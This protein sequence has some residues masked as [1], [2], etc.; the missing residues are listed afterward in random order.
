MKFLNIASLPLSISLV[1]IIMMGLNI[2]SKASQVINNNPY[3]KSLN[4][5]LT[6]KKSKY[7]IEENKKRKNIVII[8]E[9]TPTE[10]DRDKPIVLMTRKEF[11][12][13][14]KS[15]PLWKLINRRT[16]DF[17]Y[18][19]FYGLYESLEY[20]ELFSRIGLE[21]SISNK[22]YDSQKL[23]KINYRLYDSKKSHSLSNRQI[24]EMT[25]ILKIVIKELDHQKASQIIKNL[26]A[27][28]NTK[29]KNKDFFYNGIII[30][31]IEYDGKIIAFYGVENNNMSTFSYMEIT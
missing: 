27:Q 16:N 9:T 19:S 21:S 10:L 11:N 23:T 6:L 12:N 30:A 4:Y 17:Q 25:E 24:S 20:K 2:D 29:L 31:H 7:N 13:R 26:Y 14:L 18:R 8:Y 15:S 22:L 28:Y 3:E 5:N 1:F